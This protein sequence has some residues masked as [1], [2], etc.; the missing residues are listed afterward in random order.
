MKTKT[1]LICVVL[2]LAVLL[3]AC[4][5][6]ALPLSSS[7]PASRTLSISGAGKVSLKPDI[8]YIYVGVHTEMP[9]AA[10]AVADNNAKTQKLIDALKAVGVEANDI[11]TSNFSIW[12]NTQYGPDGQP[13]GTNYAVDNTVYLT[14]RKLDQLGALL[15]AAVKAGANNINS[16]QFDVA[17]KTQALSD[18]RAEA[19]KTAKI[20]AEEL[21]AVAGVKLGDIQ[22]IQ[23]YDASPS[24]VFEGKGM[25]GSGASANMAVPINPGQMEI[26]VT[27]TIAYEIK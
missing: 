17:D 26:T 2:L 14:V 9:G 25:G 10:E 23:Y 21:A 11:Q 6:A 16:I 18:A 27:V 13:T 22:S 24:P 7:Q 8:A 12:Q 1:L 20:Q 15:D 4:G 3:S 19:V 5:P